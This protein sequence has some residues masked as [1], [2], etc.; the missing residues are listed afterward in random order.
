MDSF[1][2]SRGPRPTSLEYRIESPENVELVYQLAGPAVRLKAYLMD[3]LYRFLILMAV[4]I[5]LSC[6]GGLVLSD[7]IQTGLVLIVM[8]L[9]EWFYFSFFEGL[10]GQ[11]PGKAMFGLRVIHVAG[12]PVSRWSALLRNFVRALDSQPSFGVGVYGVAWLSM[13]TTGRFQRLGDLAAQTIVVQ[14]R[15]VR[16]P[17]EPIILERIDQLAKTEIGTWVPP[18]RTL[19]LI[20]EFL[21]RRGV[22]TYDQ[23]HGMVAQ[24]AL[25]LAKRLNYSGPPELVQRYPMA[26]LAKVY[27][28]FHRAVEE[29]DPAEPVATV[30]PG[31]P[32]ARPP[33]VASRSGP[34][35]TTSADAE[36]FTGDN[37]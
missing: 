18:A 35:A 9:L 17:R 11:S 27:A 37:S 21:T 7:G 13:L 33:L 26:F 20:E 3:L 12:H 34:G 14:E 29:T 15:R 5:A 1:S 32:G 22:L 4:A 28:T 8:F 10:T 30:P 16:L 25:I 36:V 2:P 19:T 23:G 24:F 31:R 6:G